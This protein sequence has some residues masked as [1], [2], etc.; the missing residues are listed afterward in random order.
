MVHMDRCNLK[1]MSNTSEFPH[2]IQ[3]LPVLDHGRLLD[4]TAGDPSLVKEL[5]N[6]YL[7][8]VKE[9]LRRVE[10]HIA[11]QDNKQIKLEIHTIK[12]SSASIGAE[13]MHHLL[14][15]VE[16]QLMEGNNELF[17]QLLQSIPPTL[18]SFQQYIQ[19]LQQLE[20]KL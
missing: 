13:Q 6:I 2:K 8:D 1:T 17:N 15:Q 9:R 19:N 16:I 18:Q 10:Q 3:A 20:Y 4:A 11:I 14:E 7:N 12:G 5:L